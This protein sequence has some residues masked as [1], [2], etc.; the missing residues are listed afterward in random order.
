L[1][2]EEKPN[3]EGNIEPEAVSRVSSPQRE[4]GVLNMRGEDI[5]P[6]Y[7]GWER[8]SKKRRLHKSPDKFFY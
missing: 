7:Q 1:R 2:K 6:F 5:S 8:G 4:V 3:T